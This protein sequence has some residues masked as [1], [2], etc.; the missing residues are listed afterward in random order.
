MVKISINEE[1]SMNSKLAVIGL[2]GSIS[3]IILIFLL[4]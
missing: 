3:V 1:W 2:I 4:D